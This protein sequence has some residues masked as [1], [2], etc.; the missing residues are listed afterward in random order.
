MQLPESI[1]FEAAAGL[2]CRFAT[3]YRAVLDKGSVQNGTTVA[4]WGC[5]GVGLS[6]VMIAAA[7]GAAVV[8]VDI[9]PK[10][11]ELASLFGAGEVVL[12]ESGSS[13]V[14]KVR[15]LLGGG[16]D[17]SID[18]LGST[19]TAT[20]SIRCLSK[21]GKHIQVGLMIGESASPVIPMWRLH[22]KEIEMHGVH[23]LPAW[24]YRAMLDLIG[25][26]RVTPGALVTEKLNLED[27]V[28]HL[29]SMDT[30]PGNGFVVI[31]RFSTARKP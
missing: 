21:R 17:V 18:A 9:D 24:Q 20:S 13:S 1:S 30:Y 12:S 14:E 4:V 2:G 31:N 27:G 25:S 15:D 11:L 19:D 23:G 29:M 5:G 3:A 16:A 7:I 8:A 6:A 26:G 28:Q 10:A 22:G